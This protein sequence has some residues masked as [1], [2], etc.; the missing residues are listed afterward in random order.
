MNIIRIMRLLDNIL[1]KCLLIAV[2]LMFSACAK[3]ADRVFPGDE[4]TI[5]SPE[6]QGVDHESFQKALDYLES[7][8]LH[9]GNQELVVIRNGYLIH[10]GDHADSVH[11]IW[12]CSKTFT[13]TVLGLLIEDGVID[14]DDLAYTHEPLLKEQYA[15]VSFR[16]FATMTSGYSAVGESRWKD[17]DYAD[18]S[19]TPYE[20]DEP[21]FSPG[22]AYAYWDEAQMMFGRVQ[23]RI[24]QGT[25]H[26]FLK[27]RVTDPI[28][29]G[30]W[31]WSPEKTVDGIPINNGCTNVHVNARQLARW[32]WLF[33][34]EGNWNGK[35]LISKD[36]IK[37]ATA[38]QVPS[39]IPVGDT[40][41]KETVGPGCYGFNWWVNGMKADGQ[42]KLPGAPEGCYFASGHNNNKC[43]VIPDWN[44][45]IVRMGED[46]HPENKDLVYGK[47]LQ[48]IGNAITE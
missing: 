27:E 45:V 34:N 11:N 14:L 40:D 16:H 37:M 4:W 36:W 25:M 46:G 32:G 47:F 29:M 1:I 6:E 43:I 31:H 12:S 15:G 21:Y 30:A 13:S 26:D 5:S 22:S 28:G 39:T 18:W 10:A 23:T 24:L 2:T 35:Q 3:Q 42:M 20:P 48:M 41:R 33:L 44:M 19:L 8:S 7:H 9:N 17:A 38:V